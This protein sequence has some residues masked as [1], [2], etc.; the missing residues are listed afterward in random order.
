MGEC[1]VLEEGQEGEPGGSG[2]RGNFRGGRGDGVDQQGG[3]ILGLGGGEEDTKEI[4]Y[5]SGR[6]SRTYARLL[7]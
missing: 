2:G 5:S 6:L 4:I 3:R 1:S 7:E